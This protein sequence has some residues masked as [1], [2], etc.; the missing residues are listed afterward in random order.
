MIIYKR[1]YGLKTSSAR[2]HESLS[3]KICKMGF[4]PS[5]TNFNLWV[6]HVGDHYEYVATYVDD[7]L[8]FSKDPM[9]LIEEVIQDYMLKGVGKPEYYLGGNYH[10]TKDFDPLSKVEHD[11]MKRTTIYHPN[12]LKKESRLHS[13][14]KLM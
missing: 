4:T 6:R 12:G 3:A 5:K 9:S 10:S 8:V 11:V 1:L 2:F 7:I 14:Q 13:L